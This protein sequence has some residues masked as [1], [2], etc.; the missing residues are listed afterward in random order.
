MKDDV[1]L[2][3][4]CVILTLK[5]AYIRALGRQL[6]FDLSR[7]DCD[8]PQQMIRVDGSVLT[9]W[10][11]RLFKA[12][13]GVD[14]NGI[15]VE[16]TYQCAVAIFR[17]GNQPCAFIWGGEPTKTGRWLHFRTLDDLLHSLNTPKLPPQTA[18]PYS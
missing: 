14:R 15:L 9:G 4:L 8:I 16:E 17:G 2:R 1:T 13:L 18:T 12:N 3:R 11:F 5:T 7:V 10:E 6:G